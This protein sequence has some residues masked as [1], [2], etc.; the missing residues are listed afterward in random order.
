[1]L[2]L[3][4]LT[5]ALASAPQGFLEGLPG[6]ASMAFGCTSVTE[7]VDFMGRFDL[8]DRVD[9]LSQD[10]MSAG[11]FADVGVDLNEPVVAAMSPDA[12]GTRID[13]HMVVQDPSR[14]D[15]L[16]QAVKL[17]DVSVEDDVLHW[18]I[19]VEEDLGLGAAPGAG[20]IDL[21]DAIDPDTAGCWA[22]LDT[23]TAPFAM[24]GLSGRLSGILLQW[25]ADE[26]D[27]VRLVASGLHIPAAFSAAMAGAEPRRSTIGVSTFDPV[28]VARLNLDAEA[29]LEALQQL[30]GD[31]PDGAGGKVKELAAGLQDT[32]LS[33]EPGAEVAFGFDGAM[34]PRFVIATPLR[35]PWRARRVPKRIAREIEADGGQVVWQDGLLQVS[36][37]DDTA[38]WIGATRRHLI[39]GNRMDDVA[40]VVEGRGQPW[41]QEDETLQSRPGLFVRVDYGNPMI[42]SFLPADVGIDA[43]VV[44]LTA[45]TL[46]AGRV[47]VLLEVSGLNDMIRQ[48]IAEQSSG[49]ALPA[50]IPDD[51]IGAP[52]SSE[53]VAVL[54]LIS[55]R[56][57]ATKAATGSYVAYPGGPRDV[58]Q[59]DA[60][61]V[62]WEGIPNLNVGAMDT[63][64]RYE[65]TLRD[66][67]YTARAICDEDGDGA[68]A[69]Y[70]VTPGAVPV[71][72]TP[73]GV[74]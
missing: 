41:V 50:P 36:I 6:S 69:I 32:R 55:A 42:Q 43:S 47:E 65:V 52:P 63:A 23:T 72:V 14:V 12:R 33:I 26:V 2:A 61:P 39:V 5:P 25:Y 40:A 45:R 44:A 22:A 54:M 70:L 56:E 10:G 29:V 28:L 13:V 27:R 8:L 20:V 37:D 68:Q 59:L 66:A 18:S 62:P 17:S 19:Y 31:N 49:S 71:R 58:D 11:F 15:A 30:P 38:A 73:A 51:P 35:R 48:R 16:R 21:L 53:S 24:S 74:R 64:C 67:S 3:V 57:D 4:M 9:A 1:M 46:G 60:D 34:G 7:L